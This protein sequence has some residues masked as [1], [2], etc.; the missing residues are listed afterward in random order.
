MFQPARIRLGKT[1]YQEKLLKVESTTSKEADK[2]LERQEVST[3]S[4]A[5]GCQPTLEDR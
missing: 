3:K 1:N 5:K 4:L 2:E